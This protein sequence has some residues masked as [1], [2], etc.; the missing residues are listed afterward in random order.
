MSK[1]YEDVYD[2]D[3]SSMYDVPMRTF[4]LPPLSEK[5]FKELMECRK[6]LIMENPKYFN[7][8]NIDKV[9]DVRND[10]HKLREAVNKSNIPII[11]AQQKI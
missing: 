10:L 1:R 11:T 4:E 3:D 6:N 2:I 5:Q 9:Y 7:T 8:S